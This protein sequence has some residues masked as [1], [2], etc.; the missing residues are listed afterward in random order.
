MTV[1]HLLAED[2][3]VAA[4]IGDAFESRP[5]QVEMAAG[6]ASALEARSHLLVEAGTGV[7]KSFAYLVP[8]M[9]RAGACNE[10]VVV[11]TNTIALQEQLVAKDIPLLLSALE[12][13]E[14][15][16]PRADQL[17][18]GAVRPVLVKG[19]SN[20]VSIRRLRQARSRADTLF[21]NPESVRSLDV[22]EGWVGETLDGSLSSMPEPPRP[23]VWDQARSDKDNCMG[24]RCPHHDEC[25]YQEARRAM[26]KANLLVCN[27]AVFFA[28]LALRM[29]GQGML[30]RY[31]HVI[32]DEAHGVEDVASEH[33]GMSLTEGQVA[34]LL[35]T[36]YSARRNRGY[37]A[38]LPMS[39][40]DIGPVER[41]IELTLPR[42]GG[43][44]ALL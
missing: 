7:G 28:D 21:T 10:T 17:R 4:T 19:R 13:A 26:E 37:L 23:E 33:L 20:Y 43:L 15:E 30:P 16:D 31:D 41:A 9:I 42:R 39:A 11:A 8:A 12:A 32:L 44:E 34:H 24:R 5:E 2:G 18:F 22:L 35:R 36:L 3:P 6:V 40:G 27:H 1:E 14:G 29:A 25:F 38:H